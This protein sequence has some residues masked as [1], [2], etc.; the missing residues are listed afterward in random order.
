MFE[1]LKK[2]LKRTRYTCPKCNQESLSPWIIKT[3]DGKICEIGDKCKT[4]LCGY[5]TLW[6]P[7]ALF[8]TYH[9]AQNKDINWWYP[10][11]INAIEYCINTRQNRTIPIGA[12]KAVS[13]ILKLNNA[14]QMGREKYGESDPQRI[15]QDWISPDTLIEA[16]PKLEDG[17]LLWRL[18]PK[19]TQNLITQKIFGYYF[20]GY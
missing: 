3:P 10:H 4:P 8:K 18:R 12:W 2:A 14:Y 17:H 11:L 15:D 19:S 13:P 1:N 7:S 6:K 16:I 20:A 9:D 5:E